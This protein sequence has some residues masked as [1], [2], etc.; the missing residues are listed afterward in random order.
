[1]A[2]RSAFMLQGAAAPA[3]RIV[4]PGRSGVPPRLWSAIS[5]A[6][7]G[8]GAGGIKKTAGSVQV[9]GNLG[10]GTRGSPPAPEGEG[11][12]HPPGLKTRCVVG[13]PSQ[14]DQ[15]KVPGCQRRR[16]PSSETCHLAAVVC[17]GHQ[18]L[19]L[20]QGLVAASQPM[21]PLTGSLRGVA[22]GRRTAA[23]DE[24][25]AGK[26]IAIGFQSPPGDLEETSQLSTA[27][28]EFGPGKGVRRSGFRGRSRA[29]LQSASRRRAGL[30]PSAHIH[31][32]AGC[33]AGGRSKRI[34]WRKARRLDW[35]AGALVDRNGLLPAP[36]SHSDHPQSRWRATARD[37]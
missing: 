17:R 9:G 4:S 25:N 18:G 1:M 31:L 14:P 11:S 2:I 19:A 21:E 34:H 30:I 22:Q 15:R 32:D 23:S 7:S 13:A 36:T 29:A 3:Q 8:P 28:L 5:R 12:R 10:I 24:Q 6:R 26:K 27:L 20:R 35:L 16:S 33:R 37:P